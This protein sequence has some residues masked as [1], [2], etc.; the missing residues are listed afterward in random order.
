MYQRSGYIQVEFAVQ[1]GKANG[2][3]FG[4]RQFLGP[5]GRNRCLG[6][7]AP[8]KSSNGY[9]KVS[10]QQKR[11]KNQDL[12]LGEC[13][14]IANDAKFSARCSDSEVALPKLPGRILG[15]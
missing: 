1:G 11:P 4:K 10:N 6:F 12:S 8:L 13:I 15:R 2:P 7:G 3:L 5:G 14:G 9:S